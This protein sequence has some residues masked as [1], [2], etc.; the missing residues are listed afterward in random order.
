MGLK[1]LIKKKLFSKDK[2]SNRNKGEST[3]CI[4]LKRSGYKINEKNFRTRY[5]E[6]DIIAI[7]SRTIC[8]IEVKSRSRKD[9][10]FPEEFV[11]KY[12]QEKLIKTALTYI[13]KNSIVDQD[14]RFDIVSVD[15]STLESRIIKNAFEVD[16]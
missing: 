11:D 14:M 1:D 6:I 10:G 13:S 2:N 12:K 5:G 4:F 7:E 16:I 3:A 8:F 15:L 9:Y